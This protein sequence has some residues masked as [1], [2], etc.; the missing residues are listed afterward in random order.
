MMNERRSFLKMLAA[1]PAGAL[2]VPLFAQTGSNTLA[3]DTESV[4]NIMGRLPQNVIFTDKS[5][6][7]WKGKAGSHVPVINVEKAGGVIKLN[8][9]TKHAM[10][11]KH[12]IVRHTV[13]NGLG[14][15]LGAKTFHWKDEPVSTHEIKIPS[16]GAKAGE[17][18]VMSYCNL[19]D[20][21]LAHTKLK[22]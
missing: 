20:L 16:G 12:Y 7:V 11:E 1:G 15:V 4:A 10:S 2:L 14:E 21:W 5:Q 6:G 17:L 3:A 9:Q 8:L 13:V 22:V 19:H 18:F